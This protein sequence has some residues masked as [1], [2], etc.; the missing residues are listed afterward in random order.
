M[1]SSVVVA[2]CPPL[3]DEAGTSALA[4][5][6]KT[7]NEKG[8]HVFLFAFVLAREIVLTCRFAKELRSVSFH[9][10]FD[11]VIIKSKTEEDDEFVAEVKKNLLSRKR[12]KTVGGGLH[13]AYYQ[14]K[15]SNE[16]VIF[17]LL[18]FFP[19]RRRNET[20]KSKLFRVTLQFPD[21]MLHPTL[22][23]GNGGCRR[24]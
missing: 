9:W 16:L 20:R 5:F 17:I 12:R 22:G 6:Q 1:R 14:V 11:L 2:T 8:N 23:Q 4:R 13:G 7:T 24:R 21:N 15:G 18:S 10:A 19:L 3:L